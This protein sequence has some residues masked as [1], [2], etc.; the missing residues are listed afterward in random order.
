[1][2]TDPKE[3]AP[4]VNDPHNTEFIR[5]LAKSGWLPAEASRRLAVSPGT[6]SQY[7]S[8]EVRP[9]LTILRLFS[10]IVRE[11]LILATE[12]ASPVF[13]SDA[14]LE[15]AEAELLS[16]LRRFKPEER[17][18]LLDAMK[19]ILVAQPMIRSPRK[20]PQTKTPVGPALESKPPTSA[21]RGRDRTAKPASTVDPSK[22]PTLDAFV[23]AIAVEGGKVALRSLGLPQPPALTSASNAAQSSP[24]HPAK[25]A[26]TKTQDPA[27]N[28]PSGKK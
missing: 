11:P 19:S 28:G 16:L 18:K 9:S 2:A 1:M 14:S 27:P 7:R 3:A 8:G 12:D 23:A 26:K 10:C 15:P 4:Y 20:V 5:L 6:I 21:P 22:D 13:G 17:R 25:G 24:A